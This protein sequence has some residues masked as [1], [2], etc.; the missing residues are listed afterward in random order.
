MNVSVS[1]LIVVLLIALLVIKPEQLPD[2]AYAVGRFV[3]SLRGMFA[4]MKEEM[5]TLIEPGNQPDEKTRE[6][7]K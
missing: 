1:E 3:S 2:V 6:H 4:R 5:N 7:I